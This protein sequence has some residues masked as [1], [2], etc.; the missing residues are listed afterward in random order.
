MAD[1]TIRLWHIGEIRL[2][3][4]RRRNDRPK[5]DSFFFMITDGKK[6]GQTS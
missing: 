2:R 3:L 5:L 1:T 4:G 6:P